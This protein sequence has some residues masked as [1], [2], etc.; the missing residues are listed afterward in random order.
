VEAQGGD[1]HQYD[2]RAIY[3]FQKR[4]LRLPFME[5]FETRPT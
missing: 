5:V 1:A 2:R 4:N 3:L